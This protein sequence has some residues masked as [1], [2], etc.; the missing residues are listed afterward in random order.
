M[1]YSINPTPL[2]S[3]TS[4]APSATTDPGPSAPTLR[5]SGSE[6]R[7]LDI[8]AG[9]SGS[10]STLPKTRSPLTDMVRL[11]ILFSS[12]L[13][14]EVLVHQLPLKCRHMIRPDERMG[15]IKLTYRDDPDTV[16]PPPLALV[17]SQCPHIQVYHQQAVQRVSRLEVALGAIRRRRGLVKMPICGIRDSRV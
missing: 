1:S 4:L 2:H 16:H 11:Y 13:V 9:G 14:F 15:G 8:P 12:P 5:G 3:S 7:L 10:R 6:S 17:R